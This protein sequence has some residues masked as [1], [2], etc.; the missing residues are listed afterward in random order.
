MG[1]LSENNIFYNTA[2]VIKYDKIFIAY[3]DLK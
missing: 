3:F 1:Q 2:V